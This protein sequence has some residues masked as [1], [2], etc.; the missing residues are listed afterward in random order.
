[1]DKQWFAI[2]PECKEE[3]AGYI[4]KNFADRRR[5]ESEQEYLEAQRNLREVLGM[6]PE[7]HSVA[8][9]LKALGF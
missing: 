9:N 2:C 3:T 8:E 7:K 6:K 5:K 1:V 4:S